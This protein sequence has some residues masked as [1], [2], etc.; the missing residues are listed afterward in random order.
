MK[1]TGHKTESIY[2]RYAIAS[3]ADLTAAVQKLATL[4][5]ATGTGPHTVIAIPTPLRPLRAQYG[6]NRDA[7][8]VIRRRK[9]LAQ[10]ATIGVPNG[11]ELEPD[12]RV[13]AGD[14]WAAGGGECVSGIR[15][16]STTAAATGATPEGDWNRGTGAA[17]RALQAGRTACWTPQRTTAT[18]VVTMRPAC[19]SRTQ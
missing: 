8:Q 1:L 5:A 10:S 11:A 2:R 4:H 16:Y 15:R 6:H 19:S 14:G 12:R 7:M 17:T 13:A 18:R 9:S 3:E